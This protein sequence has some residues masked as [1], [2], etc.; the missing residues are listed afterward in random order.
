MGTNTHK[1][2]ATD[3]QNKD[4]QSIILRIYLVHNKTNNAQ[5]ISHQSVA[6][7]CHV[8]LSHLVGGEVGVYTREGGGGVI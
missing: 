1:F 5:N 6:I 7:T 3:T 4:H 2:D 8:Q